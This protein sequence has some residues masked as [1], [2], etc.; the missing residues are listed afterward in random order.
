MLQPAATPFVFANK[1]LDSPARPQLRRAGT[2]PALLGWVNEHLCVR[3]LVW[4]PSKYQT[5]MV[6]CSY[7][8]KSSKIELGS[9]VFK[10]PVLKS[11]A[12][13]SRR[14]RSVCQRKHDILHPSALPSLHG[15]DAVGSA[16]A[17]V[18][19]RLRH[20]PLLLGRCVADQQAE[21]STFGDIETVGT[22]RY[23][24][25]HIPYIF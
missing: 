16:T 25:L 22:R 15:K 6:T 10:W 7:A 1:A 19:A 17:S 23:I 24:S 8:P 3:L 4:T 21:R 12:A 18:H 9:N 11:R 2:S 20:S 5:T 13:F 14:W